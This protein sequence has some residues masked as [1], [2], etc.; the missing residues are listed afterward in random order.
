MPKVFTK[1]M[2]NGVP[3]YAVLAISIGILVGALLNVVLPVF[4]K[5]ADSILCMFIV[6]LFYLV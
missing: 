1:V 6:R 3:L 4:I 5:G 2:R